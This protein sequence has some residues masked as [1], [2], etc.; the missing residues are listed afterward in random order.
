M[1]AR[2]L[3]KERVVLLETAFAEI[4][5]WKLPRPV[6]GS[7]HLYK[8]RMALVVGEVCVLRY[9]NEAGKG[10]HRH[11]DEVETPLVFRDL[12]DLQQ[13]F[14]TDVDTWLRASGRSS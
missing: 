5:V 4:V 14:W 8:Y 13:A 6:R 2:L 11:I 9:D 12:S 1:K 7:Q 3:L 10:D